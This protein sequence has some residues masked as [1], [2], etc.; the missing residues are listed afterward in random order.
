MYFYM[1]VEYTILSILILQSGIICSFEREKCVAYFIYREN[2]Q[3]LLLYYANVKEHYTAY[4]NLQVFDVFCGSL[5]FM[6]CVLTF[7]HCL[8]SNTDISRQAPPCAMTALDSIS[9]NII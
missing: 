5:Q 4:Y 3:D 2:L 9:Y 7:N 8:T 1:Y 6:S